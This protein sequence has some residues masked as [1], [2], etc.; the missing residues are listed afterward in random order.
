MIATSAAGAAVRGGADE[1][2]GDGVDRLLRRGK[3][4]A[5]QAIAAE[6][7]QPLEREREMGAALVRRDGVDLV[8]DDRARGREHRAPGLGAEQNVERLRRRHQDVRRAAA[9][10]LALGRGRV[11]G[12]DPGADLDVGKPAAAQP[13]ADAGQRRLEVAVD[14]VRQRLERR[15]VDD[16]GRVGE[17]ALEALPHQ[18]VDRGQKGRQRLAR[19]GRRG[20]QGVAAGLDRR[21]GFGL[22]GRRRGEAVGEP[23]R[24]PRDGTGAESSPATG[25]AES[26]PQRRFAWQGRP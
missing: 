11:A 24:R 8:D 3:A 14:V 19:A 10:A 2:M 22:G 25:G 6:R 23:A 7:R 26:V 16:L 17:P 20:D 4:D 9:H 5:L 1:E 13:F 21:P 15:D 12:A 18:L